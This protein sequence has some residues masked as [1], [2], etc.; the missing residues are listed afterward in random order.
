LTEVVAAAG[1]EPARVQATTP[2]VPPAPSAPPQP[3]IDQIV[4][5]LRSTPSGTVEVR[6]DPP[7]LG[8]VQIQISSG[9]GNSVATVTVERE[10]TLDLLRR[11]EALLRRELTDAGLGGTDLTFDR[12]SAD[13]SASA[14]LL[15]LAEDDLTDTPTLTML[16]PTTSGLDRRI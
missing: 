1:S 13:G 8:R 15:N 5:A 16:L 7:E 10:E 12:R 9:D 14:G 11:N 4:A 3:V 2:S 6:L